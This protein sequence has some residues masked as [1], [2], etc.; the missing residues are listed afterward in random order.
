MKDLA[1]STWQR[2]NGEGYEA[3]VFLLE[4]PTAMQPALDEAGNDDTVAR[5]DF[6]DVARSGSGN[7]LSSAARADETVVLGNALMAAACVEAAPVPLM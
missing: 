3:N 1:G 4:R 2:R 6:V 7:E 5:I